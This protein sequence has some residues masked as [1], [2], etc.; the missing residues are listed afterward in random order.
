MTIRR[1]V[2]FH[3][4]NSFDLDLWPHGLIIGKT[5][6]DHIFFVFQDRSMLFGMWVCGCRIIRRWVVYHHGIYLTLTFDH[7]VKLFE[8]LDQAIT[9][10]SFKKSQ[11][12]LLCMWRDDNK[13][14]FYIPSWHWFDLDIWPQSRIIGE[15]CL[16]Q[17]NVLSFKI[18]K[19]Y[20]V[21]ECNRCRII[22]R[23]VVYHHDIY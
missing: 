16:G 21:C 15:N 22:K 8:K 17:K 2:A 12:Y 5:W 13:T 10:S 9:F 23:C 14:V 18:G 11:W 6:P 19:L 4:G 3:H 7:K 1:Y 20:L